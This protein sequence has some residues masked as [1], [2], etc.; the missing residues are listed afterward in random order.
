MGQKYSDCRICGDELPRESIQGAHWHR[1]C[2]GCYPK[3][4]LP[5]RWDEAK[6][7]SVTFNDR[8]YRVFPHLSNDGLL[9]MRRVNMVQSYVL[10]ADGSVRM[11][12]DDFCMPLD[13][14][15]PLQ[16]KIEASFIVAG[17]Q[18]LEAKAFFEAYN[19]NE[20]EVID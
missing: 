17:Y 18:A 20:F 19:A 14:P 13:I 10:L 4:S 5:G 2:A 15:K 16:D 8:S 9:A 6:E 1:Q 12:P 7:I 11:R 3:D